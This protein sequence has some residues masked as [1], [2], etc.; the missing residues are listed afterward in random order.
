MGDTGY[1]P[2]RTAPARGQAADAIVAAA[3]SRP[4]LTVVTLGPLTNLALAIAGAPDIVSKIGRCVV[5]G[6]ACCT[7][8]N[9]T[10]AAEYNIWCDPEAAQMC[11]RSGL[12][13]ELVGWE[14]CRGDANLSPEDVRFVEDTIRTPWARVAIDCN[15][16]ALRANRQM[17]GDPGIPLPDPVAMAIAIDPSVCARR[18]RHYVQVECASELTRGMTVVDQLG[19]A[20]M[21]ANAVAWRDALA[22]GEPNVNVCWEIDVRRWKD[23]LF[24]LLG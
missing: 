2:P 11:L 10:P 17:L 4:G 19:V 1:A 9:V 5:M 21:P 20:A 14:L 23:L 6:G 16:S 22:A 7:V 12:P 18:S 3:R 15:R 8:G 13:I 24:R